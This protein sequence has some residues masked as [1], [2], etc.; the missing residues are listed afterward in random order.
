MSKKNGQVHPALKHGGYSGTTLLPGEDRDAF[1]KLRRDLIAEFGPIGP[2]EEDIV[3]TMA[4][5]LWRKQNLSTYRRAQWAKDRSSAIHGKFGP[6]YDFEMPMLM[7]KDLRSA[8]QIRADNQ[9]ADEEIKK[10]LGD[11]LVFVEMGEAATI[12]RLFEEL[13]VIDRLNG[14]IDRCVKR[15]LMVRG[16]KSMSPTTTAASS[17]CRRRLT[18]A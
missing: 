7:G 18:A 11:A 8:D 6:R 17:S 3:A 9:S 15:L 12:G 1:E 4:R 16:V 13:A 5:L 2:L 10:E 14:M